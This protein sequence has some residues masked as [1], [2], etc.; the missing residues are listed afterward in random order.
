MS[1]SPRDI[2]H[3]EIQTYESMSITHS[4]IPMTMDA[5]LVETASLTEN[6]NPLAKN[7][8]VE[9]A[10]NENEGAPFKNE[11]VCLE[12]NDNEP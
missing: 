11:Q 6:N 10:I 9:P 5:P 3:G 1:S 2:I 7:L 4:F 8:G 12:E